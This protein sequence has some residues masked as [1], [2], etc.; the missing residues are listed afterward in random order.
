MCA[1][2]HRN[3][4][5]GSPYGGNVRKEMQSMTGRN[6]M[7]PTLDGLRTR[8]HCLQWIDRPEWSNDSEMKTNLDSVEG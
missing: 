6:R 3:A 8:K 4:Q 7:A 5:I 1:K 2:T